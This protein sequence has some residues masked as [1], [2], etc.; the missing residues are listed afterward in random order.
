[1]KIDHIQALIFDMGGTIYKPA[2]DL[3][4]Q[5][6]E[7]LSKITATQGREY[8]DDVILD[9]MN[10]P[11]RWL[12]DYMIAQNVDPHWQPTTEVWIQYDKILLKNL[13][14]IE[15]IDGL[16]ERYQAAWDRYVSTIEPTLAE[17]C[18]EEFQKLQDLGFRLAIASNRYGSPNQILEDHDILGF[19]EAIEYSN[20]PGYRKP[21]PYMLF[22][23]ADV[24]GVNP[25]RCAYIGNIVK[26]DVV[27]AKNAGMLPVLLT[28]YD[29]Q[30]KDKV[31]EDTIIIEHIAELGDI[32]DAPLKR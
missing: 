6:R 4:G 1:M 14:V 22:K 2:L 21:S 16:A 25:R 3:C 31:T 7:F 8:S 23:V 24:L 28:W 27:A 17:G 9:A 13:G 19:F 10:D 32:L 29:P 11:D 15:D 18:K 26:F 20:V 12:E 30:E 5:T